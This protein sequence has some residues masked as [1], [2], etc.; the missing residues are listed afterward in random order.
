MRT[1]RVHSVTAAIGLLLSAAALL[2]AGEQAPFFMGLGGLRPGGSASQAFDISRDGTTVVGLSFSEQ[3]GTHPEA[4]RWQY[5]QGMSG[6]GSL[7]GGF[8]S[9]R[10]FG[11]SGDG[12][13]VVGVSVSGNG[14]EAFRWDAE[15]GITG[16]GDLP[17]GSFSS[18]ALAVNA[19]GTV[20]V[21]RGRS[22]SG[23][24]AFRWEDGVMVGLGD[25]PGG[26]FLSVARDVS[27]DGSVVV[28]YGTS[29]ASGFAA[30]A[31]RWEAG[32]GMVG[33]GDLEGGIFNS[34]AS[35]VSPDGKVVVGW[36]T[37]ALGTEA[38]RWDAASGM[39]GLGLLGLD[40]S[41]CQARDV[42][43]DGSVIVG[44][45]LREVGRPAA[46]LWDALHGMRDLRQVLVDD[47]GL[48]LTDWTLE[49]AEG[50]SAD[51]RTIT[52]SGRFEY[53]P[54]RFRSE[55]WIARIPEPASGFLF[56]G[57]IAA[58]ARRARIRNRRPHSEPEAPVEDSPR[59]T[60]GDTPMRELTPCCANGHA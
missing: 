32:S 59:R 10:A 8:F 11:V 53:E 25:L 9:S 29:A 30:E 16:L 50:I 31:F 52:G 19:D 42:S 4:F 12:S 34:G 46:F 28:G 39:Q 35:A 22:A 57:L 56:L 2:H 15:N 44:Y 6:L 20:I 17:G 24:E 33:L 37:S 1:H 51:G 48:D 7:E 21:G 45:C 43:A 60:T 5:G 58:L 23:D 26:G 36:G 38:M 47:F 54:G 13:A 14:N 41:G 18:E 3:S 27:A 55:G 49:F 40:F